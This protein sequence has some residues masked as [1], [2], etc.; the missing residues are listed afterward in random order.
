MIDETV[1]EIHQIEGFDPQGRSFNRDVPIG[2]TEEGFWARINYEGLKA[3]TPPYP[4]VEEALFELVRRLQK[5]GFKD[6]RTRLNFREERY[7]A[8]TQPWVNYPNPS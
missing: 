8:E 3:D 7:F 4:T 1:A 2:F 5:N 6:L